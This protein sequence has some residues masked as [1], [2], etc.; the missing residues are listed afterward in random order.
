MSLIR[1]II[2]FLVAVIVTVFAISN[3]HAATFYFSPLHSPLEFPLYV[4]GL[5][6]L[7][8]GFLLGSLTVWLNSAPVRSAR[9]KQKKHIKTLEKAL[10]AINENKEIQ[11]PPSDFFPALPKNAKK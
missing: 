8:F 6:L 9:R 1:W 3:R 4:I 5:G 10:D 2:G 7:A 11:S